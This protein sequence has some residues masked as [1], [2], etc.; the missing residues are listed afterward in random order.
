MLHSRIGQKQGRTN[1]RTDGHTNNAGRHLDKDLFLDLI[2]SAMTASQKKGEMTGKSR[3]EL[4]A[5]E[6]YEKY[7]YYN[8]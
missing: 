6:K 3:R 7:A 8:M 4:T 2:G 1:E 5:K